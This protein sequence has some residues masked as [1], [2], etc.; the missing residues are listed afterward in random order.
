MLELLEKLKAKGKTMLVCSHHWEEMKR[1]ADRVVVLE[2]GKKV[3]EGKLSELKSFLPPQLTLTIFVPSEL[4]PSAAQVLKEKGF[5]VQTDGKSL[6]V[7]VNCFVFLAV[8]F[9]LVSLAMSWFGLA[10]AGIVGVAGFG[11]TAASLLNLIIF[12]VP[13]IGLTMGATGIAGER[14]QGT[15]L[16]FLS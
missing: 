7:F 6:S 12:F 11:R 14:E 15:L 2:G 4:L 3:T 8:V 9:V 5:H 10:G 13:L 1:L 16:S